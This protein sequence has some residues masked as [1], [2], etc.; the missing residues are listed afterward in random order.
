MNIGCFGKSVLGH[1]P[2]ADD[3]SSSQS[4]WLAVIEVLKITF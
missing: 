2:G 3:G 4:V 1:A